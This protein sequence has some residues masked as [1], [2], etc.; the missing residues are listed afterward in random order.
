MYTPLIEAFWEHLPKHGFLTFRFNFRGVGTSEGHYEEGIGEIQ[1]IMGAVTFLAHQG[2]ESTPFF[3]IG[4]SFGAYVI[5]RLNSL[6]AYIKGLCLVSPPVSMTS[7]DFSAAFPL[8]HLILAGD[9]DPY[10]NLSTL[11]SK[12]KDMDKK[13]S[14]VILPGTDHFWSGKEMIPIKKFLSWH[15]TL[16]LEK[17]S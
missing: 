13:L 10:C 3:L 16:Q 15:E 5:H 8:P 4:Y 17:F 11:R 12:L 1:D 2:Y 14:L 6:P 9:T 7:F